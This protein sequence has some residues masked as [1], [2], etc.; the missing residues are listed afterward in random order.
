MCDVQ[1]RRIRVYQLHN[2]NTRGPMVPAVVWHTDLHHTDR[3][4]DVVEEE[5]VLATPPPQI[6]GHIIMLPVVITMLC[7]DDIIEGEVAYSDSPLTPGDVMEEASTTTTTVTPG[8]RVTT[9]SVI[10]HYYLVPG[11]VEVS[12][13]GL[14]DKV[15]SD[16][17]ADCPLREN[18]QS[19]N[20]YLCRFIINVMSLSFPCYSAKSSRF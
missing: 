2:I 20:I 7:L 17:G 14:T 18:F 3:D 15:P 10:C 6:G 11:E 16:N 8:R 19:C 4:S 13:D 12:V 1:A 5:E 9:S